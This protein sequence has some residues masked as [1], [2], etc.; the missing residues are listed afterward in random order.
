[1]DVVILQKGRAVFSPDILANMQ[2]QDVSS[3]YLRHF[4]CP[5]IETDVTVRSEIGCRS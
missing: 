2:R 4:K 1:V 3:R 5:L